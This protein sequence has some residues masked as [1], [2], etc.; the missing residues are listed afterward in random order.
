MTFLGAFKKSIY[1]DKPMSL[2]LYFI[3]AKYIAHE[4]FKYPIKQ[5]KKTEI[6]NLVQLTRSE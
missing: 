3:I 6:Y 1:N 5:N 4:K 2:I